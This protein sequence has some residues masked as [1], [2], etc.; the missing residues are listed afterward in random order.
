MQSDEAEALAAL[1][2]VRE[3]TQRQINQH[4][5]RIANTAEDSVLAEFGSAVEAVSCAMAL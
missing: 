4:R 5:G 3:A 2:A 1:A